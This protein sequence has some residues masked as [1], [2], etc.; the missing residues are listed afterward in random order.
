MLMTVTIMLMTVTTIPTMIDTISLPFTVF[1]IMYHLLSTGS[2]QMNH[3]AKGEPHSRFGSTRIYFSMLQNNI[4]Q[5]NRISYKI[6]YIQ[7]LLD[8][9]DELAK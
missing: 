8:A 6:R 5:K 9:I 7:I 2:S 3:L 1:S 4:Q